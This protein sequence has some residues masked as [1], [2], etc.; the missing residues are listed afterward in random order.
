MLM[1]ARS[2]KRDIVKVTLEC[3]EVTANMRTHVPPEDGRC[4][5]S[6]PPL[7]YKA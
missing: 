6:R 3:G 4:C 5:S 7:T 2:F 1:G